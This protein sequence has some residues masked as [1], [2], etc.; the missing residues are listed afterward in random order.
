MSDTITITPEE[1]ARL[2]AIAAKPNH[3]S[4][5]EGIHAALNN[6]LNALEQSEARAE[7][8]ES[9]QLHLCQWLSDIAVELGCAC[10]NEAMLLAVH[11]LKART[12]KAEVNVARLTKEFNW[13][14]HVCSTQLSNGEAQAG[15]VEK[16]KEAARRAV[17]DAESEVKPC[18]K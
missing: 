11:G 15:D 7:R 12:E 3:L 2:R 14:A 10:D 8:A 13:M 17:D 9:A 1:R 6:L 5:R 18:Q 4:H 16:W